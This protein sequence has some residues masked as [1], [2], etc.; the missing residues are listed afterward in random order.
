[1]TTLPKPETR[2]GVKQYVYI[3]QA[4]KELSHCKIG[5]TDNLERRLSEY[6]N[7]TGK[8]QENIYEYLF[9]CRVNNM[10]QVEKDIK[11][12]FPQ[13]RSTPNKEVYFY[14]SMLFDGYVDFIKSHAFFLEQVFIKPDAKKFVVK[15]VRKTTPSLAERGLD[16]M[17]PILVS[18]A[19]DPLR[20]V[21]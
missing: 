12:N 5:I 9:T 7:T 8:S 6:N 10:R 17:R 15:I 4:S 11:N 14:N 3:V 1:M 21:G 20:S 19:V 18:S 2:G 16:R 13:L